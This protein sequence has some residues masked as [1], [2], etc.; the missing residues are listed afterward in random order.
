MTPPRIVII[1]GGPTGLGAAH[2]LHEL[3]HENWVLLE[4]SE[5]FGGLASTAIDD[6]GFLWDLG[7]H[8]LF[9]HYEYFDHLLDDLIGDDWVSHIREAWIWTHD[10]WVPYPFQNNLWRLPE[11]DRKKC[12][13]GIIE[14]QKRPPEKKV[15][16]FDDWISCS[17]GEGI[18]D[19][20]M[21]PYNFKVW[22]FP[23]DEL[24]AGWVGDRVATSNLEKLVQN[25][26]TQTDDVGWGPN[27]TFR[28]PASGG[29]G[30][31]W[32]ALAERLPD[33]NLKTST[34]VKSIN[35]K[36]KTVLCDSGERY[37]YD[38]LISTVPMNELLM[39]L[40]DNTMFEDKRNSFRWS[41]THVV[42]I[43]LQGNPQEELRQK[44]WMYYPEPNVPFYRVTVFSNY[45]P[46]NVPSPGEQWSLLCEIS[47]SEMKPVDHSTVINDTIQGLQRVGLIDNPDQIISRWNTFLPYGYPTPFLGRDELIESIEPLL[48]SMN[49]YSRGRF[50]G[51]KY[52]V[53]NQ[54]HSLMQ[55][56]EAID[57]ILLKKNEITYFSPEAV[58]GR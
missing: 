38:T 5:Q 16:T 37:D 56:V 52:E 41:S 23:P 1:G 48:R 10:R 27:S 13:D 4:R 17:L 47:E 30:R 15:E 57:Q 58:N 2:R 39:L 46:A 40:T 26:E 32:S 12:I 18:A 7:G 45:A 34:T 33:S 35:P 53:S 36:E 29:T 14:L 9:S 11:A 31:I 42:G 54:D 50:G 43:G 51:W 21:R 24:S 25:I 8:V 49:I 19:V 44:C 55:G 20:F 28:F 6:Q 3:E 22:A